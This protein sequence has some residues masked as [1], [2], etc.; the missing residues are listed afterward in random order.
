MKEEYIAG[1]RLVIRITNAEVDFP[2]LGWILN[3]GS[4][5]N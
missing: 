3:S 5:Y 1:T 2:H 4:P